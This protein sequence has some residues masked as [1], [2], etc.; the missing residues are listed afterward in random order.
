MLWT[1]CEWVTVN[2]WMAIQGTRD[3]HHIPPW[4]LIFQRINYEWSLYICLFMLRPTSDCD[5][6]CMCSI[7]CIH[8]GTLTDGEKETGNKKEERRASKNK[9]KTAFHT[10]ELWLCLQLF[11]KTAIFFFI[12]LNCCKTVWPFIPGNYHRKHKKHTPEIRYSD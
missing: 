9:N 7:S 3:S 11:N 12:F 8:E 1:L 4:V 5:G 6:V 10:N 2:E